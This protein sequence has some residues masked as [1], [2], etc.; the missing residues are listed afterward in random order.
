MPKTAIR[1]ATSSYCQAVSNHWLYDSLL[2]PQNSLGS[3]ICILEDVPQMKTISTLICLLLCIAGLNATDTPTSCSDALAEVNQARAQRGLPPFQPDPLLSQAAYKAAQQR[4]ARGIEGHLPESDF[5]CLP[6][7]AMA[8]AAG[9]AAWSAG[10][11]WG[12]CCTYDNYT[13]AGAAWVIGNDGRRYMHLFV[14]HSQQATTTK[15]TIIEPLQA[16]GEVLTCT[17][18]SCGTVQQYRRLSRRSRR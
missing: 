6:A 5:T 14:R 18:G 4:A 16:T 3:E 8:D 9:C 10:D 2:L 15:P 12:S 1:L 11:G 7:G 17:G 13:Y